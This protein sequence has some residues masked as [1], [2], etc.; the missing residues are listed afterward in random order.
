MGSADVPSARSAGFPPEVLEGG[1]WDP[2]D[3]GH[4]EEERFAQWEEDAG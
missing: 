1:C 3:W 2:L 4:G